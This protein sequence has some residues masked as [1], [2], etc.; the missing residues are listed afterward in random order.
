MKYYKAGSPGTVNLNFRYRT[1][2]IERL[3]NRLYEMYY[4][5][6]S[7]CFS[8][9]DSLNSCPRFINTPQLI[10]NQPVNF[11]DSLLPPHHTPL[12]L[13]T[14]VKFNPSTLTYTNEQIIGRPNLLLSPPTVSDVAKVIYR[15]YPSTPDFKCGPETYEELMSMGMQYTNNE[16]STDFYRLMSRF[17]ISVH[18]DHTIRVAAF[19]IPMEKDLARGIKPTYVL[20]DANRGSLIL[21][22][23]T[24]V[25]SRSVCK[26]PEPSLEITNV[27]NTFTAKR[28]LPGR[29]QA[30]VLR[31]RALWSKVRP[32]VGLVR[33]R[34]PKNF[35]I[36]LST[37]GGGVQGYTY[38]DMVQFTPTSS[39]PDVWLFM[40]IKASAPL[41]LIGTSN[42]LCN[43]QGLVEECGCID[44][45]TYPGYSINN[46][47]VPVGLS[48]ST[49]VDGIVT[50]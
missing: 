9:N 24:P 25:I 7:Y 33:V 13:H 36:A 17:G 48:F 40:R 34:A 12:S 41:G 47:K 28:G 8:Q 30:V 42:P 19:F 3:G 20:S 45:K 10:G 18:D 22:D 49:C 31:G 23:G 39:F 11:G 1:L 26:E 32:A 44:V 37:V 6:A 14:N 38:S 35:E 2:R 50:N 29:V 4:R 43:E 15:F 27:I 16:V 21:G 46:T 5:H